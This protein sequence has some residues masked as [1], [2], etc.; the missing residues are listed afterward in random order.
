MCNISSSVTELTIWMLKVNSGSDSAEEQTPYSVV[1]LRV[2]HAEPLVI[3][4]CQADMLPGLVGDE[5]LLQL[6]GKAGVTV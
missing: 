4:H 1:G 6:L 2:P 3:V 5:S